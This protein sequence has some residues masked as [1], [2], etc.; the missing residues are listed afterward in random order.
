M[1]VGPLNLAEDHREAEQGVDHGPDVG[2]GVVLDQPAVLP[3]GRGRR[4]GG[5]GAGGGG[6]AHAH[7]TR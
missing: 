4:G 3:D 6:A 7:A 1:C 2:A 5:A